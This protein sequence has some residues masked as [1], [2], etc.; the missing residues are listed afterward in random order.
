MARERYRESRNQSGSATIEAVVS[1]TGFLFVIF[2]ILNVVNFCRTQMLISNAM[3]TVT[4]EL[5]Q[6]SYFYQVSGLQK[7]DQEIQAIGDSGAAN[8]N[9]VAGSVGDFYTALSDA[10]DSTEQEMLGLTNSLQDGS[11]NVDSI[12][13]VLQEIEEN[14][15]N[16]TASI[17]G[18]ENQLGDV[19]DNPVLYIKSIVAVA[20]S[21]GMDMVKSHVLAAPLAKALMKKHFG[22]SEADARLES[23]GVVDG[24]DGMN[25]GMST[26][27][28]K[29]N[30]DEIHLVVYYKLKLTQMFSWA[31]FEATLCKETRARAWLGGDDVQ[32]TVAEPEASGDAGE[33]GP[34][35]DGGDSGEADTPDTPALPEASP[36]DTLT[37]EE[38]RAL[39]IERYGQDVVDAV[40]AGV[41]T[42]T[43]QESDWEYHIWLYQNQEVIEENVT[44]DNAT[45]EAARNFVIAM[46][47]PEIEAIISAQ[48]DTS[49]WTLEDWYVAIYLYQ[50]YQTQLQNAAAIKTQMVSMYGQETVDAVSALALGNGIDTTY[51]SADYWEEQI[52]TYLRAKWAEENKDDEGGLDA[53]LLDDMGKF[54]DDALENNYQAYVNRKI[55]KGQTPK[56]RLEWKKASDYWTKESPVARGNNFNKTVREADIYDYHEVYLENGKRLD[57]YDPDAGEIISRKATDLDK[58]TEETYRGYL[59]E[60]S[61][62]YSE[63]TKIRSNA[64]PELDGQELKGQYILEIPASNADISNIDYYKQIAAEYDVILRFTEEVQ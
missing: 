1:F 47:G 62:K 30:P 27:F 45:G 37:P 52:G 46:F 50:A 59:S 60:F 41:D 56:D 38:A 15:A 9:D 35:G 28:T 21:E 43:W 14:G 10:A 48:Y 51:W 3:D 34:G 33:R 5:T 20:G 32:A 22:G 53:N 19:V 4:K 40:S 25:F 6:Y 11:F 63:G 2:T 13:G 58:I 44:D 23:L 55:S 24:L 16:I 36:E 26:I 18:M 39:M 31:D 29:E 42:S 8:L 64:Y 7:F 49:N 12:D 61:Q 54:T 57:S 17:Q